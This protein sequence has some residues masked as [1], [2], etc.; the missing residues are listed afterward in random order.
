M[1]RL[2]CGYITQ[3]GR[4]LDEKQSLYDELKGILL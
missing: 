1:L 3:S 2:I 4:S